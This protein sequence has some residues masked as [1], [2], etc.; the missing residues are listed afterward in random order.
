MKTVIQI[1]EQDHVATAVTALEPGDTA[2]VTGI[3]NGQTILAR[4]AIPVG[5]K[6]A[7]RL[8]PHHEGI[9]K[10]GE[11][12]GEATTLIEAGH[13]VHTHNCWGLKARRFS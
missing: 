1:R 10:Y 13:W 3:T 5:H 6:I 8:I 2:H 7:L 4:E 12:I 11:V 9:L